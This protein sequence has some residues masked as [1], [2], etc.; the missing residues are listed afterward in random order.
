MGFHTYKVL[1]NTEED[2]LKRIIAFKIE[3]TN[4]ATYGMISLPKAEDGSSLGTIA[5]Y[6]GLAFLKPSDLLNLTENGEFELIESNDNYD[7]YIKRTSLGST[8]YVFNKALD[9]TYTISVTDEL[10]ES[11]MDTRMKDVAA[12]ANEY[13]ESHVQLIQ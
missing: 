3:Y 13:L 12:M 11:E 1:P 2:G 4:Y 6:D 9:L 5:F 8:S 7:I 10:E